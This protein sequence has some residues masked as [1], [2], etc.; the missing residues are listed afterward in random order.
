V[1]TLLLWDIDGTLISA[2]GSGT[3]ALCD[4][5]RESFGIESDLSHIEI[6]GRTDRWIFQQILATFI[7]PRTEENMQLLERNYLAALQP[8]IDRRGVTLLPGVRQILDEAARFG[9]VEQGLLTGNL[10]AGAKLKLASHGLWDYFHFGAFADDAANRN[11]LGPLAL[12]R[13]Q[14]YC[15]HDFAPERVW[16][17]GDTPHDITCGKVC[18]ART[19]AV[20]TGRNTLET[21]LEG[22]PCAAFRDLSDTNAFWRSVLAE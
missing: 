19:L 11:E 5:V 21:L 8:Q 3:A 17:I 6:Q 16:V 10:I 18:G 9:D 14:R 2:H 15:G 20:A 1:K 13:A 7:I 4:S 22:K 12:T